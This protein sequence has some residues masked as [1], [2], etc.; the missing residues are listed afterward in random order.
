MEFLTAILTG[1]D[2]SVYFSFPVFV[3]DNACAQSLFVN[4]QGAYLFGYSEVVFLKLVALFLEF[5]VGV[6]HFLNLLSALD[7]LHRLI[8]FDFDLCVCHVSEVDPE[9]IPLVH[10]LQRFLL[11]FMLF[12]LKLVDEVA[13]LLYLELV[14]ILQILGIGYSIDRVKHFLVLRLHDLE[15]SCHQLLVL[16]QFEDLVSLQV[17]F[18]QFSAEAIRE[19]LS[20]VLGDLDEAGK[21]GARIGHLIA[22]YVF[23]VL[24]LFDA[25]VDSSLHDELPLALCEL[26]LHLFVPGPE[27]V[28]LVDA[29]L[30]LLIQHGDF[31]ANLR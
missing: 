5:V 11:C 20:V 21:G 16:F 31:V 27:L 3:F 15:L 10:P 18:L 4:D 7:V 22:L 13:Q 29:H 8:F 9:L 2:A 17:R 30:Q 1:F 24:Q 12:A 6:S 23:L 14:L 19:L 25:H 26:L 28:S